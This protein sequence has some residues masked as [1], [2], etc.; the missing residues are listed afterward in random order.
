[1]APYEALYE[2]PCRSPLCWTEMRESSF[3]GPKIAQETT[4]KIRL[5]EEKLKIVQDRQKSYADKK[6]RPLEFEKGDYVFVKVSP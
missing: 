1:M 5:I 4:K 3:L 6:R 2:R